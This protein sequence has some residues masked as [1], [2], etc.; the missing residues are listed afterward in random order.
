MG[1]GRRELYNFHVT[2]ILPSKSHPNLHQPQ[3][4]IHPETEIFQINHLD[5]LKI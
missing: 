4:C 1:K 3:R 5:G 2:L